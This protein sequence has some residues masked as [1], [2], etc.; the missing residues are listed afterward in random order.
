MNSLEGVI[1]GRGALDR[2]GEIVRE[3][4]PTGRVFLCA[5]PNVMNFLGERTTLALE[6]AGLRVQARTIPEG[7]VSKSLE[8]AA[9]VYHWLAAHRAE[10]GEPLIALGGGCTGDLIGFVAA[11][12]ARGIPLVQIPTTLLAQIDSSIGGKVAVDLPAGKNLVGAFYPAHR[13]IIDPDA[14]ATLPREQLVAD[15]A[16]VIKTAVIFDADLF[17]LIEASTHRLDDPAL[18]AELVE[19]CVRWKAK[20]VDEDPEDRGIRAIL[21]YGHT[22]AHAIE[23]VA[24]YG[25]YRHG[26]AVAIGMV[27]A[28]RLAQ[29]SGHWSA[30]DLTR[31]N[32]LLTAIGLPDT[33]SGV[34]PSQV[35][36]AMLRDK[37]VQHG[38]I[39]WVLPTTLGHATVNNKLDPTL[40]SP[41]VHSLTRS[42]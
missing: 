8:V 27:G 40:V 18:L 22:I 1:I 29:Q 15:Y 5:D 25:A 39:R 31:Q 35:L 32:N 7:E 6:S 9:D 21:N 11:T 23:T 17:D 38:I 4:A 19:R 34:D 3:L 37:K 10:R 13:V 30:A 24:G 28:G 2:A 42:W 33:F 36:D 26:E 12:Y 41:V 20:V 14:L 16:E